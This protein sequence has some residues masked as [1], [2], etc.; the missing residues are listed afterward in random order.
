MGLLDLVE[1][2]R[3]KKTHARVRHHRLTRLRDQRQARA[4]HAGAARRTGPRDPGG[5]CR[6]RPGRRRR[7]GPCHETAVRRPWRPGQL[8]GN[9]C[10]MPATPAAREKIVIVAF[11]GAQSLDVTGP[12]EVFAHAA[13]EPGGRPYQVVVAARGGGQVRTSS[14]LMLAVA[15]LGA[16]PVRARRH[17][18][19][20]RR[21]R[22]RP[23]GGRRRRAPAGVGGSAGRANAPHRLGLQR[24]VR[25]RRGG[26]AGRTHRRHALVGRRSP[27][28][29]PAGA[30]G[31]RRRNLRA[32]RAGLDV[33]GNHDRHRHVAGHRRRG[34]RPSRRRPRERA[35]GAARAP[36]WISVAVLRR[37]G[38]PGAPRRSA[39]W[40]IGV[41][42]PAP[43]VAWTSRRWPGRRPSP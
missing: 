27:A 24:R 9:F 13:R 32:R 4:G 25:A 10:Q 17:R 12:A 8:R 43:G 20:R 7:W 15:A 11:D 29:V 2:C 3:G 21:K 19:R 1:R 22:G 6:D 26:R 5:S 35:A 31:R 16:P 18:P 14:G 28:R 37:A 36:P 34:L 42:Q 38:C 33:R 41:G 39:E 40:R 23:A 30:A